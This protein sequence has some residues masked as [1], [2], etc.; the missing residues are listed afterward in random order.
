MPK[1]L[2]KKALLLMSHR[3]MPPTPANYAFAYRLAQQS[4]LAQ[5]SGTKGVEKITQS[6]LVL[7]AELMDALMSKFEG[8]DAL[9]F[10]L[11]RLKTA[12][13]TSSPVTE[14]IEAA[15][16]MIESLFKSTPSL[17]EDPAL[18]VRFR[19]SVANLYDEVLQALREVSQTDMAL[20]HYEAMIVDCTSVGD[21]MHVL[22][23]LSNRVK[24]LTTTL[25][26]TQ[27]ALADTQQCLD[28]VNVELKK[29]EA[30]AQTLES[31][32]ETDP[33]TGLLNRRGLERAV[34]DLPGG[35]CSIIMLDIDDFKK[36]NDSLG[37][38]VGDEAIIA[39]SRI[40]RSQAREGDYV[41]RLGGEE[42]A[43]VLPRANL[44]QTEAVGG[45]IA[46]QLAKWCTSSEARA[47]KLSMTFS[48]GIASWYNVKANAG[49]QFHHAMEIADKNLYRAKRD[50]KNRI[51][52]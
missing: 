30:R 17:F 9:R 6:E 25:K 48:A 31:E 26:K 21:A 8:Q 46:Q 29:T 39:L 33:L 51:Q 23:D 28:T 27:S 34:G 3:S 2:A 16:R 42:I 43:L 10:D 50:G 7:C 15:S 35:V 11:E 24:S 12:I 36:I 19:D 41:V 52:S 4:T 49:T 13:T 18:A 32:V 44:P 45:R 37:H 5:S 22:A 38:A 14:Q 20:P 1:D 40:A 47:L